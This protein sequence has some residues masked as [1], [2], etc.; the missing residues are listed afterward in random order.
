MVST[1]AG[2][3]RRAAVVLSFGFACVACGPSEPA[4]DASGKWVQVVAGGQHTCGLQDDGRVYC[5][6]ANDHGQIGDGSGRDQPLPVRVPL[7]GDAVQV[8]VGGAHSCALLGTGEVLCWGANNYG[9]L[10][11]AS[12][13]DRASPDVVRDLPGAISLDLGHR[14]SCAVRRDGRVSCWGANDYGQLGMGDGAGPDLCDGD[15]PLPCATVPETVIDLQDATSV[16]VGGEQ[17]GAQGRAH[18]CAVTSS[19]RATCWGANDEGQLGDTTRI[20]RNRPVEVYSLMDVVSLSAGGGHTCAALEDGSLYCWG[21]GFGDP[22]FLPDP[23]VA[24]EV[25]CGLDFS[26]VKVPEGG[27]ECM[28]ENG[29]GQL[30]DGSD[31]NHLLGEPVPGIGAVIQ[32]SVGRIHGCATN[33]EGAAFC[34]GSNEH[35]QLGGSNLLESWTAVPVG[36]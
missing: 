23:P 3:G 24:L 1:L 14:N 31:G 36:G 18:A 17:E 22:R 9:Q 12:D 26:C 28:G 6:G 13:L 15:P 29:H 2:R 27:L 35:G 32:A 7:G 30:G 21:R 34:W 20:N 10:G 8:A 4:P 11:N 19:G 16:T 25:T 33:Q 5:W